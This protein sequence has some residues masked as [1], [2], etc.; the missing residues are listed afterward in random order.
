VK[1]PGFTGAVSAVSVGYASAC[2]IVA[3]GGVQCWGTNGDGQLGNDSKVTSAAPVQVVGITSGATA[4][5]V[6]TTYACA[7][8]SGGV[9]CWGNNG[10]GASSVP[11]PVT[12]LAAG[13]T[14]VSI[15][16]AGGVTDDTTC[17]IVSGGVLC[18]GDNTYGELGDNSTTDS[19]IPVPSSV[20]TSG[21]TALSV[22]PLPPF[23]NE[24]AIASGG[25][26]WC[27]GGHI[28]AV[29]MRVPGFPQ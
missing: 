15:G 26:V 7:V 6:G 12:G 5:S 3:G 10:F 29:P 16:A 2:A 11:A 25:S 28:G 17:A 24:C 20:L 14:A 27:W 22:G 4:I 21:V 19:A 8:V 1:V 13:A 18:W 9:Q 23:G